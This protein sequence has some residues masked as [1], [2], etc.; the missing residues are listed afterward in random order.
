MSE[1]VEVSVESNEPAAEVAPAETASTQTERVSEEGHSLPP[2][3]V[4]APQTFNPLVDT[5]EGMDIFLR[6]KPY[7]GISRDEVKKLPLAAQQVIHNLR[8]DY[9]TKT[10]KLAEDR[11][12]FNDEIKQARQ[13]IEDDRGRFQNERERLLR[14]FSNRE[15]LSQSGESA[16][17]PTANA[18]QL[19]SFANNPEELKKYLS[20]QAA[21]QAQEAIRNMLAPL[22][23][24]AES[25]TRKLRLDRFVNERPDFHSLKGRIR[26]LLEESSGRT[27]EDA[28]E[29]ARGESLHQKVQEM[30]RR[31]RAT[32]AARATSA[33]AM[34]RGGSAPSGAPRMPK[35]K[36]AQAIAEWLAQHPEYDP[37]SV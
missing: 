20:G 35:L 11:R 27:L 26:Q 8:L 21:H 31:E 13:S 24:Q 17:P 10:Q 18:E 6:D 30:E 12:G 15:L 14:L 22:Q 33:S 25:E 16:A 9:Q 3:E 7:K 1:E 29:M 37:R 36:G 32:S 34:A 5:V 19:A 2:Q 4:A 23:Q 28:Y